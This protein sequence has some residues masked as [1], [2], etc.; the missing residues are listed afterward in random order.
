[1]LNNKNMK[2][3]ISAIIIESLN[4]LNS[5]ISPDF[6]SNNNWHNLSDIIFRLTEFSEEVTLL[7]GDFSAKHFSM[8]STY[9]ILTHGCTKSRIFVTGGGIRLIV[10]ENHTQFIKSGDYIDLPIDSHVRVDEVK[11]YGEVSFVCVAEQE[12]PEFKIHTETEKNLLVEA[13]YYWAY[14]K[15]YAQTYE[16][17]GHTW[18]TMEANEIVMQLVPQLISSKKSDL[19]IDLG[20]GEGR[21]IIWLSSQGY[22]VVG[23]DVSS[24]ALGCARKLSHDK[25]LSPVFLE[26]DVIFLRGIQEDTYTIAL[27]MGCLHMLDSENDRRGHLERVFEILKSGGAFVINHCKENWLKGFWSVENFEEVK[28]ATPGDIIPRRIRTK[29]GGIKTVS[30]EVLRHRVM[31]DE[32][33]ASELSS[34]GFVDIQ[35]LEEE[36]FTFGNS[37][38]L[39]CRKP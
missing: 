24:A 27:N 8:T 30:M 14:D 15:R 28:N 3:E 9:M 18:E 11:G 16:E 10:N 19:I 38:I 31:K 34:I 2:Y 20:C 22:Q 21:D 39:V 36:R 33:L 35:I 12:M 7:E 26:R 1:M 37:A 13:P 29:D 6:S 4:E 17:G 25:G 5:L 32:E 23:V